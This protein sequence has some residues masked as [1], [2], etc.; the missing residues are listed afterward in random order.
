MRGLIQRRHT[1]YGK[2][3]G[4]LIFEL[5]TGTGYAAGEPNRLDAFFMAETISKGLLRVA[6]EIKTSRSDFLREIR[7][8]RKRRAALRVSN[9][10]YFVTPQ[11]PPPT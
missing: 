7:E 2:P 5:A 3:A 9:Q 6:Y 11:D 4:I 1:S 8:P 10:F